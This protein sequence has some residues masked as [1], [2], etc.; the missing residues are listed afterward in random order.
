MR[1]MCTYSWMQIIALMHSAWVLC[2]GERKPLGLS[3]DGVY[4]Y[5]PI[6][7]LEAG[8]FQSIF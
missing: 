4:N 1:L 2:G 6:R 3:P 8:D 7:W 5:Y